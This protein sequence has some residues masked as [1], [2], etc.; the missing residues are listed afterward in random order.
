M[1]DEIRRVVAALAMERNLDVVFDRAGRSRHEVPVA[2][3]SPAIA[4]LTDAAIARLGP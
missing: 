4:D 1:A 3:A 2:L